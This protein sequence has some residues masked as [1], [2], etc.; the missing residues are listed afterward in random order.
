M[1]TTLLAGILQYN[2]RKQLYQYDRLSIFVKAV[3]MQLYII[4][5]MYIFD[6]LS[7]SIK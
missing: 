5:I 6:K 7:S 4:M 1:S 2:D 3:A